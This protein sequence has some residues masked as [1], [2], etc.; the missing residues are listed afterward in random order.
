MI[1]VNSVQCHWGYAFG[2]KCYLQVWMYTMKFLIFFKNAKYI[3]SILESFC[4]ESWIITSTNYCRY[5]YWNWVSSIVD[6]HKWTYQSIEAWE[7]LNIPLTIE[8]YNVIIYNKEAAFYVAWINTLLCWG[9]II[10]S[11][12]QRNGRNNIAIIGLLILSLIFYLHVIPLVWAW[13][14]PLI[15]WTTIIFCQQQWR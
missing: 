9:N 6:N 13:Y 3:W 14:M 1:K 4:I 7:T 11:I 12:I 10:E 15:T 5:G 2:S 8:T